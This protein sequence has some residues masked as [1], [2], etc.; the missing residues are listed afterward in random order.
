MLN[1]TSVGLGRNREGFHKVVGFFV[2][3]GFVTFFFFVG[4]NFSLT[5]KEVSDWKQNSGIIFE[6]SMFFLQ[7]L[8]RSVICC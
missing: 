6:D 5:G 1:W 3:W 8:S 2:F 7:F 4:D